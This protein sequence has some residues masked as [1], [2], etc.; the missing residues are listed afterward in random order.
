MSRKEIKFLQKI[1]EKIDFQNQKNSLQ[2]DLKN[3]FEN[4]NKTPQINKILK[5]LKNLAKKLLEQKYN[6]K[7]IKIIYYIF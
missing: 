6:L 2:K 4:Q 5:K 7:K 3:Y 1:I